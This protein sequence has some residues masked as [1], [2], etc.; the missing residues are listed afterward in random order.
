MQ[1]TWL[2]NDLRVHDNTAL[3][4]ALEQGPTL[5]L[6]LLSPDQW[7]AH[8]EAPAKVDFRLRNLQALAA[9]LQQLNVP[10][11]IRSADRWA[12]APAVLAQLCSQYRIESVHANEEY[13]VDEAARDAAV[14]RRLAEQGTGFR[15]HLDQLLCRPGT[16]LTRSGG[17]FKVFSQFR[18]ACLQQL[19]L[20]PPRCL[21]RPQ[22]QSA[23]AID[24]DPLPTSV[25]GFPL[26][27]ESLRKLWPA[28]EAVARQRLELFAED[29]LHE[30]AERRD[31]PA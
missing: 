27:D 3:T 29:H 17:Y 16:L 5:A 25:A 28:G 6:F 2:R 24:S 26:P 8:D 15:S 7:Q 14:A 20:A 21:P 19:R 12:S 4:A 1:L 23:L 10:L 30:Y 31:L 22:P 18:K 9:D 13:G 11:L